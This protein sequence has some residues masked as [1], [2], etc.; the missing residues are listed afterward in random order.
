M[1]RPFSENHIVNGVIQRSPDPIWAV[2]VRDQGGISE[3]GHQPHILRVCSFDLSFPVPIL[4]C[5]LILIAPETIATKEANY[6]CE[7]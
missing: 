4:P 7:G 3:F 2:A 5:I 6:V 1:M